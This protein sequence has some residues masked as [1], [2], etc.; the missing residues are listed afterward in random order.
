MFFHA[1]KSTPIRVSFPTHSAISPNFQVALRAAQGRRC[2]SYL[3]ATGT[4]TKQRTTL[5]TLRAMYRRHEPITLMTA[6]DFPSALIADETD[7]VLV[8]DSLSMVTL[9][10]LDTTQ[11]GLEDMIHHCRSV[12]RGT[13]A[14]FVVGDA[15]P[16]ARLGLIL[17]D[18][19]PADGLLRNVAGAGPQLSH[20][21]RQRRPGARGEV[22]RGKRAGSSGLQDR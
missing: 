9:G 22:G 21:A 8:G 6:S 15:R 2:S 16:R 3:S 7:I 1:A 17:P 13:K 14:S 19:R 5:G 20:S 12:T 18:L 4:S 10:R 11:V